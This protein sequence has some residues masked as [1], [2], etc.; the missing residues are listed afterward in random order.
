MKKFI[1]VLNLIYA[2]FFSSCMT[3]YSIFESKRPLDP[4]KLLSGDNIALGLAYSPIIIPFLAVDIVTTPISAPAFLMAE[5]LAKL[6]QKTNE[7]AKEKAKENFGKIQYNNKKING[8]KFQKQGFDKEAIKEL[9]TLCKLGSYEVDFTYA[10]SEANKEVIEN[11]KELLLKNAKKRRLEYEKILKDLNQTK[12]KESKLFEAYTLEQ[13]QE[14]ENY[15]KEL[16]PKDTLL[17]E[18]L[19]NDDL[20]AKKILYAKTKAMRKYEKTFASLPNIFSAVKAGLLVVSSLEPPEPFAKNEYIV[21]NEQ[22]F[23]GFLTKDYSE[24][25]QKAQARY[26]DTLVENKKN[27]NTFNIE[28][29]DYEYALYLPILKPSD[30]SFYGIPFLDRIP[31]LPKEAVIYSEVNYILKQNDKTLTCKDLGLI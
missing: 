8:A 9:E 14:D 1:L 30:F 29:L 13:M 18:R 3:A 31:F 21:Q 23:K 11:T 4:S 19:K 2:L 20:D 10:D 5:G 26:F 17:L 25:Y 7:K 6:E 24:R 12:S 28:I 22:F 15:Y 16:F 27:F